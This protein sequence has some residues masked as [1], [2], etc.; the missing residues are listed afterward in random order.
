[1]NK[2]Q[3]DQF[4]EKLSHFA[5][6]DDDDVKPLIKKEISTLLKDQRQSIIKKSFDTG[7]RSG[8]LKERQE[9]INEIEIKEKVIIQILRN[10]DT[11]ED[12]I[13]DTMDVFTDLK[14]LKQK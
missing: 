13:R 1:M 2:K 10:I 12:T 5:I 3:L 7:F 11:D 6:F 9:I 14:S 8:K 4:I